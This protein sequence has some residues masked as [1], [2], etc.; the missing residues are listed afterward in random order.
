[1]TEYER[2]L[3]VAQWLAEVKE[4]EQFEEFYESLPVPRSRVETSELHS[5]V[6]SFSSASATGT[7][8]T[9]EESVKPRWN[10]SEYP[11]IYYYFCGKC[12]GGIT[13]GQEYCPYCKTKQ[14]WIEGVP[15]CIN[16]IRL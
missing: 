5:P 14:N 7:Q 6:L 15:K 16:P 9:D 10:C 3:A 12:G 13:K 8:V 11:G 1:M 2:E 4:Q